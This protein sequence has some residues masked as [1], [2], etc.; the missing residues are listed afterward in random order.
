MD[1]FPSASPR[2]FQ[3]TRSDFDFVRTLIELLGL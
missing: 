2:P 1:G 3:I